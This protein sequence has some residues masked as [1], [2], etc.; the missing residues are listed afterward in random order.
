MRVLALD[1]TTREGSVAL[2]EDDRIILERAGDSRRTHAERLPGD[3]LELLGHAGVPLARIELFAVASGP[4]SFTGLRIGTAT[5]QGLAFATRRRIGAISA[6][7]ALAGVA[8]V[9][10]YEGDRVG[11]W[12]DAYRNDVF[13]A[14]FAVGKGE[15][16]TIRRL[17]EID[18]PSVGN[19][20]ATLER[21]TESGSV[22]SVF[23]GDGAL[24]YAHLIGARGR[25]APLGPIAGAIGRL[26]VDRAREGQTLDPSGVQPLYV[27][28]PDAEVAREKSVQDDRQKRP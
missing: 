3:I 19:P 5:I 11:A 26:A 4:G 6:L 22:P 10:L 7:E 25:V 18:P 17:V 8:S 24:A 12:M 15:L 21:W 20:A 2:V 27:R 23:I 13:S 14:L 1:T 9:D 28:R 16:F